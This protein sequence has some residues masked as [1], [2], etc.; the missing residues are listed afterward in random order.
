[1]KNKPFLFM[2]ALCPL[3]PAA[4]RLAYG[5]VLSVAILWYFLSGIFFK[6]L[7]NKITPLKTSRYPE[8]VSIAASA[9]LFHL[10][11]QAISPILASNLSLY[12]YI[13]AFSYILMTNIESFSIH[14]PF[15]GCVIL[16]IPFMIG[17][18]LLR[19][20]AG[21][22]TVSLPSTKG[23]YIMSVLPYFSEWGLGF[24]GT[25]GGA[26]I[27]LGILTWVITYVHRQSTM[28]KRDL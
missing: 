18:S 2:L 10:I 14:T 13:S 5:I 12:L 19:E 21:S 26:L 24:W 3:I 15:S 7:F 16:F 28:H 23:L 11:L 17:F 22:G 25:S 20:L 6:E 4:S 9:T 27:I 8:L 1:M